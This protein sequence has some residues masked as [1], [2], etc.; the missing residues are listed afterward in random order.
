MDRLLTAPRAK[1]LDEF[2]PATAPPT[3][4]WNWPHQQLIYH[5]LN[6][7]TSGKI[8][9]LIINL[10]PRH[11]KTE[12]ITIR[13]PIY[14]MYRTPGIRVAICCYNQ[15]QANKYSR[16]ARAAAVMAG[17]QLSTER[18]A[19]EEWET[20]AGGG[21]MARGVGSG[22]TGNGY[23]LIVIDDPVKSRAEAESATYRD[24]VWDWYREDIY[25]RLEP[26]GA[27]I[28]VMTRWHEDDLVGRIL[29]SDDAT[30]W[31]AVNLPALAESGDLLR[32]PLGAALCPDRYDVAELLDSKRVL[33]SYGFNAL[34]QGH[35][36]PPEGMLLKRDW[37]RYYQQA[38]AHFDAVWSSWDCTFKDAKDSDFVVGQVWGRVRADFYLLDQVRGRMGFVATQQAIKAQK[39]KWPGVRAVYIEDKA[40]GTAIIE[41]LK[42]DIA[43]IIPV[44]PE[45]G[46]EARVHA[47]SP[48]IEAGNVYLPEGAPWIG[49]FVEECAGFLNGAHDDQCDAMSQA[50]LHGSRTQPPRMAAGEPRKAVTLYQPR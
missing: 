37:W 20:L 32:R 22:V 46:K 35:P 19:T 48:M 38:P 39:A 13:Y 14:R 33:G 36:S 1:T 8:K 6:Q 26:G 42:H 11:T 24:A 31:T 16:R 15:V 21:M 34:F 7:V 30:S 49:D 2:L 25:T 10:P 23:D 44:N 17:I 4:V 29:A 28:G 47:I 27:I 50:L 40:N 5:Y 41:T 12:T 43:G 3:W 18:A 9:R 45:G